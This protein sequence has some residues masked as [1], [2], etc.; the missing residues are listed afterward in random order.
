MAQADLAP[1]NFTDE[2]K[3][4]DNGRIAQSVTPEFRSD[5]TNRT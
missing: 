1:R 4:P 3:A 5:A 2:G